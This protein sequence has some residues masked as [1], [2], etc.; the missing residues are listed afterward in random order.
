MSWFGDIMGAGL[1]SGGTMHLLRTRVVDRGVKMGKFG[2][3]PHCRIVLVLTGA[4]AV[5]W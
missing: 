5:K 3:S 2:A 4:S 1:V